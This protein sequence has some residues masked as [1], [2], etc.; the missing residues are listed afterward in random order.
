MDKKKIIVTG[1]YGFIGSHFVNY[2]LEHTD[3]EVVIVDKMTYAANPTNLKWNVQAIEQDI[4]DVTAEQLGEFDYIVHF[5]A[6][7]HVDNSIRDGRP[8]VRTNVE[9]T[10]NILEIARKNKNLKKFIHIS[11]DEVY[12]DVHGSYFASTED[13]H[14]KPSSYYSATKAASDLLVMAASRTYGLPYVI[15]RT[16]NNYGE[17]QHSEKF[18]PTLI[19]SVK[20]DVEIPIYG[21]GQHIREWIHATDNARAIY[22]IMMSSHVNTTFNI[23]SKDRYRN[24]EI[25]NM[26]SS[27]LQKVA[28]YK[29]VEDR[30]GHDKEYHIN[31]TKYEK[32]F[33]ST[34]SVSFIYWLKKTIQNE[35]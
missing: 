1:G 16:C 22:N 29:F 12:G 11:T 3:H 6:E 17:N 4:C 23:G 35:G 28:K 25:V 10:F 8:F 33:G 2:L 14:I 27:I 18:L 24:I 13:S 30:L 21:D 31:Y 19:R 15:T 7:S 5:A 32:F 34:Q 26:V 9:G 20:N